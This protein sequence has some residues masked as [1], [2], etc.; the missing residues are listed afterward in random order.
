VDFTSEAFLLLLQVISSHCDG[1]QNECNQHRDTPARDNL[2]TNNIR[3]GE[4]TF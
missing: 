4:E 3:E 1:F 2:Q